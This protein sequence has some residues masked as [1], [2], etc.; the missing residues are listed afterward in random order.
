MGMFEPRKDKDVPAHRKSR[1]T[2]V[3]G[4]PVYL[5]SSWRKVANLGEWVC[6]YC[7]ETS[8]DPLSPRQDDTLADCRQC[9]RTNRI[10][11]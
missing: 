6:G 9:G 8:T 10:S 1:K 3:E 7:Q 5:A 11:L 2:T 4:Y